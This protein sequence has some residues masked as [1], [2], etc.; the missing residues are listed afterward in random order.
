MIFSGLVSY[1]T[2]RTGLWLAKPSI[3]PCVKSLISNTAALPIR[4]IF[5]FQ[6]FVSFFEFCL[7]R[8]SYSLTKFPIAFAGTIFPKTHFYKMG[9]Y[10]KFF[11]TKTF[12]DHIPPDSLISPVASEIVITYLFFFKEYC[13][14]NG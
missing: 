3:Y 11:P 13:P 4:M 5:A 8:I 7:N 9:L 10:I 1:F 12:L 2:N 6:P 14:R